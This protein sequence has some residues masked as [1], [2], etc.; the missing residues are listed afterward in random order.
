MNVGQKVSKKISIPVT[1]LKDLGDTIEKL[2][3]AS[4]LIECAKVQYREILV[5]A[6]KSCLEK[7]AVE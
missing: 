6:K 5:A 7:E 3:V 4:K 1:S 2:E